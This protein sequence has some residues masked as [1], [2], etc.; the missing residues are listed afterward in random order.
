MFSLQ[1]F[2]CVEL[3][4][5]PLW[6]CVFFRLWYIALKVLK[7]TRWWLSFGLHS[8]FAFPS[9]HRLSLWTAPFS[10]SPVYWSCWFKWHRFVLFVSRIALQEETNRMSANALAIVFAPCILRCPDTIDPLQ[11]VQ[12]ISKTTAYVYSITQLPSTAFSPY[13]PFHCY[14]CRDVCNHIFPSSTYRVCFFFFF[15]DVWSWSSGNRWISTGLD[16]R[17]LTAWSL[18]RTRP[19]IDLPSLEDQW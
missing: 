19:K 17:T 1:Y 18:R 10:G 6:I 12:D 3:S 4:R 9:S 7:S 11:S 16:W 15:V 2:K 5:I 13:V 8:L 14:Y